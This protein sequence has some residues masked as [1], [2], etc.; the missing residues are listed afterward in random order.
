VGSWDLAGGPGGGGFLWTTGDDPGFGSGDDLLTAFGTS[1]RRVG[2]GRVIG[3]AGLNDFYNGVSIVS[4]RD[5]SALLA[6]GLDRG[7]L[8]E[9]T[10][11]R[12]G[13]FGRPRVIART[14]FFE[15]VRRWVDARGR[16]FAHWNLSDIDYW[17]TRAPGGTFRTFRE[18][19]RRTLG[20]IDTAPDGSILSVHSAGSSVY[21]SARR[22]GGSFSSPR[23][24][25]VHGRND[26]TNT[27]SAV[28][29]RGRGMAVW[30]VSR[31]E[32]GPGRVFARRM[33]RGVPV[34]RARQLQLNPGDPANSPSAAASASGNTI[35]A[36]VELGRPVFAR[37]IP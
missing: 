18:F 20:A 23:R 22:P 16:E 4:R 21:A 17:S 31:D 35:V 10:R 15:F 2:K 7:R 13:R 27:T 19:R 33:R 34:G 5:G 6:A 26:F 14:R 32:L 25:A 30:E 36:W 28:G 12:G 11:S 1:G 29:N 8:I 3:R 24:I 37:Y 9:R